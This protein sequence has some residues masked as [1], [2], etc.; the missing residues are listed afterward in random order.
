MSDIEKIRQKK[1]ESAGWTSEEIRKNARQERDAYK[2]LSEC[3]P[4]GSVAGKYMKSIV[5]NRDDEQGN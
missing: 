3:E 4:D 1:Q 2:K 5:K